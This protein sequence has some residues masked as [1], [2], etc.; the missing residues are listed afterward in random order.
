MTS[1]ADD[2]VAH[3]AEHEQDAYGVP[4]EPGY[5][6]YETANQDDKTVEDVASGRL[7]SRQ[8]VPG[9]TEDAEA[10]VPEDERPERTDYHDGKHRPQVPDLVCHENEGSDLRS[11]VRDEAHDEHTAG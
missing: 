9:A 10:D 7:A 2:E 8:P 11:G 4:D 5:A 1:D 3:R 6:K